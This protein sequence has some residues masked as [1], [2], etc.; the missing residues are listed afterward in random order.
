M[1]SVSFWRSDLDSIG[2]STFLVRVR[3]EP[4][5]SVSV[6]L[7]VPS[8]STFWKA[9]CGRGPRGAADSGLVFGTVTDAET[10]HRLAG[11]QVAFSWLA[12]EHAP[13]N[14]WV[15]ERP[16]RTVATDS[17]GSYYLCGTPVEYLLAARARAGRFASGLIEVIV[18]IRGI[19]RRDLAVSRESVSGAADSGEGRRGLATLVGSVHGER[20]GLLPG[21]S[22]SIEDVDGRAEAD[23]L[24]RF[25]L[26]DLPSGTHMLMVR[27]IGY[28]ASRQPVDLR[29][30]DTARVDVALAEALVLDTLRVTASPDLASVVEEMDQRR[31]AGFGYFMS[32]EEI[33]ARGLVRNVFEG[34]PLVEVSGSAYKFS[35]SIRKTL[36]IRGSDSAAAAAAGS[37]GGRQ[38]GAPPTGSI[39]GVAGSYCT[40]DIFIDRHPADAEQLSSLDVR[41]LVA[42]E[43][44][45]HPNAGLMQYMTWH[46]ECGVILVWTRAAH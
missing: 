17:V 30:R 20:G 5:G 38:G 39:G 21:A 9:A 31:Q 18:D 23:S 29:N 16:V 40:P 34:I 27:R 28:F 24:G 44:Y 8:R 37:P 35:V 10:G 11:A 19:S 6:A 25:V 32:T 43:I 45:P 46:S 33:R 3:V 2:L 14:R 36:S 22:A 41:D 42:V 7:A 13:S 12:V 4:A 1:Q 15:V 26:R